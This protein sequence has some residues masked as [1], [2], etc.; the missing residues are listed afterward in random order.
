VFDS[1]NGMGWIPLKERIHQIP[2]ILAGP[3]L[4]R[5]EPNAVT[6]WIALKQSRIVTLVVFDTNKRVLIK[7]RKKTIQLGTN[8]HVVAVTAKAAQAVLSHG[9][10]YLYN[11]A[12][13]PGET[14]TKAGVLNLE[15]TIADITYPQYELPSFAMVPNNFQDLRIIHGSCR[16]PHGESMDALAAAD[17]M[18]AQALAKDPKKRPHQLFL[19]GDQIYVDDVADALLFMLVDASK[20]LLGWSELLPVVTDPEKLHPGKRNYL[21]TRI[22]G[23]TASINKIN[24]ISHT[25]KSHLFTFGEFCTMYLFA[26]SDV[27]WPQLQDLPSFADVN[28]NSP[29]F[30]AGRALFEKELQ[31][32][33]NFRQTLKNT[34]RAL[35]NVST[36]MIFDDHE[37]TDDWYLNVTWCDRVLSKPLGRRVIQNGLAAYAI[38]QA[39]G[40]TPDY[41]EDGKPGAALLQAVA[42]WTVA[43]GQNTQSEQKITRLLNIP[44]P[45]DI[46]HSNPRQVPHPCDSLRWHYTVRGPGYEVLVLDTRTW[47]AFPGQDFDFP[48]LLSEEGC[49][50]QISSVVHSQD[51]QVTLVISP[52]PVIGVPL[53]ESIQKAAKACAQKLGSTAWGFDPE[54]WS[55][56]PTAWERLLSALASR[57]SPPKQGRVIILSGDVHY[58]FAARLQYAATRPFQQLENSNTELIVVQFTSSSLKNEVSGASGSH[59]LHQ[60]GFSPIRAVNYLPT[61]EILGW[62]NPQE[63]GIEVGVIYTFADEILLAIPLKIKGNPAKLDLVRERSWHR[64][65]E[66]TKKPDWWYRIDFILGKDESVGKIESLDNINSSSLENKQSQSVIAPLPGE[67]RNLALQKYL[68]MAKNGS[69]NC[70]HLQNGREIV[71]VNN[72]GEI[73][74]ESIDGKQIAVQTLWWQME[75][76]EKDKL[77]E[78]FPLTRYEVWLEFE[79]P[80]HPMAEVLQEVTTAS[81][82]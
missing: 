61:A 51:T 14:L 74:F 25:A 5:T 30:A 57:I 23:L 54:A 71:G 33:Q 46:R 42:E 62:N 72:I 41:F 6:V 19:T 17:K 4:R 21:A 80:E 48:A 22:A 47:R 34:R 2:L 55:L 36:Y 66:I 49:R 1:I 31:H 3:I 7:G 13:A 69:N 75:S 77:L 8:L 32:L 52:T 81:N 11:L 68:A 56:E 45:E 15:G 27:L 58:S 20:T 70:A 12:F 63:K 64:I 67:D 53:L 35:A 76:R 44:F 18:I 73:T 79:A 40:N 59:S 9:E 78:P 37:I 24:R 28:P 43:G 39:W 50:E 82:S 60:K 65:L 16:K 38:Y 26:W 10:I 29:K